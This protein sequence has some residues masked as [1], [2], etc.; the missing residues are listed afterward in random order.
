MANTHK[1]GST[2]GDQGREMAG[3]LGTATK[4]AQREGQNILEKGREMGATAVEKAR[5]FGGA[6]AT[7]V[8]EAASYVGGKAQE[9]TQGLGH[10]M[11]HVG[12]AIKEHGPQGGVLGGA[13]SAVGGG[14]ESAGSYLEDRGLSGMGNDLTQMVRRYP[15]ASLLVGVGIGVLLARLTSSNRSA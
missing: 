5:E 8:G 14:I 1:P 15:I 2:M 3:N 9:A 7:K 13:A 11:R 12:E 10:G 6:A 4:E